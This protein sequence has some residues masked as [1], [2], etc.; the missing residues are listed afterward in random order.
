MY[1]K[2]LIP[3]VYLIAQTRLE[4]DES[5]QWLRNLLLDDSFMINLHDASLIE[6]AARRCYKSYAPGINPNVTKIRED[7]TEYLYNI[8]Q[9]GHGSVLEHQSA[10]FAFENVSRV[11]THELVRHR[12]GC[13]YSQESLRYVRLD[14]FIVQTPLAL[15][16]YDDEVKQQT[17]TIQKLIKKILDDCK[18]DSLPFEEKKK[19]TSAIR[20]LVPDG[21]STGIV[22]T[23]NM[24][25]LRHI[26]QLRTHPSAE[27]EMRIVFKKV[28]GIALHQWPKIFQ[29]MEIKDDGTCTFEFDKV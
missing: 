14:N 13:A 15:E 24:R 5:L 22:A 2:M 16:E 20:R 27:E 1:G 25:A 6:Q 23:F 11:F 21:V 3:E 12:A 26:I 8:L 19:L 18:I 28:A 7:S 29:D 10:T 17:E 4:Y 9:S